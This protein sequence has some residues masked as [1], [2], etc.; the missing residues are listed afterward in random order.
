M[1]QGWRRQAPALALAPLQGLQ[2]NALSR[3][4]HLFPRLIRESQ[5]LN[6]HGFGCLGHRNATWVKCL[7][8]ALQLEGSTP[9]LE[10]LETFIG[11]TASKTLVAANLVTW[12]TFV[13]LVSR[14]TVIYL[15]APFYTLIPRAYLALSCLGLACSARKWNEGWKVCVLCF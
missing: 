10:L 3:L 1:Q 11:A 4:C 14:A 5:E 8:P 12:A 13:L 2:R 15:C 6:P 9:F 7:L